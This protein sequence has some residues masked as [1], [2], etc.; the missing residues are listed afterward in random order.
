MSNNQELDKAALFEGK[1][2]R[3]VLLNDEWWFSVVDVV[4]VLTNSARPDGYWVA[5]KARIKTE[6]GI[7]LSTIC[8]R[9]K[10]IALDGKMRETDCVNTEGL[11]RII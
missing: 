4:R 7:Q 3:K 8:R 5:M 11:L 6:D 2:I 10:L 9:L 1:K